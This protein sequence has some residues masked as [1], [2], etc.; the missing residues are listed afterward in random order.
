MIMNMKNDIEKQDYK[1][2]YEEIK[3]LINF[4][5]KGKRLLLEFPDYIFEEEPEEDYYINFS[6][7]SWRDGKDWYDLYKKNYSYNGNYTERWEKKT[8]KI[9][10][11]I[12][13]ILKK[14]FPNAEISEMDCNDDS[15]VS[16][17]SVE[18]RIPDFDYKS[19]EGYEE[20]N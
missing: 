10:K 1:T 17:H 16:N 6:Y 18:I 4:T 19:F 14:Y 20:S 7:S 15:N 12:T 9:W 2:M 8:D 3:K 5:G 11:K 13:K